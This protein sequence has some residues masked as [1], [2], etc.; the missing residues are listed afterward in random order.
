MSTRLHALH[1]A[2]QSLWLDYIDRDMLSN[3]DLSRRIREDALTGQTS[4]PTI[5]EKALAEGAAYDAQL[6]TLDGARNLGRL[7]D[8]GSL[9]PGKCADVAVFPLEDLFSNGAHNPVHG[10]V[11]CHARQVD[12]LLVHGQVRVR[13]GQLVGVDLPKLLAKLRKV[14]RRYH[15]GAVK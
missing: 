5:F 3:G 14:A 1:A 13:E 6:A 2:G 7:A 12:T 4:N 9:E 8:L 15:D 10:L 11:L